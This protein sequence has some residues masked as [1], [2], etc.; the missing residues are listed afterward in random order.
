MTVDKDEASALLKDVA[1]IEGRVREWLI[2]ARVSDYLLLWGTIWL[3]GY[4]IT[5]LAPAIADPLWIGLQVLGLAGTIAIVGLRMARGG[6]PSLAVVGR[7]GISVLSI[8]AS[9]APSRRACG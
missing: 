6:K 8:M 2:Y 4:T 1:G 7:A 3:V 9:A 5:F